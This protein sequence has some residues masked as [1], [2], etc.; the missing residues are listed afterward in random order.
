[1]TILFFLSVLTLPVQADEVPLVLVEAAYT[2]GSL[3]TALTSPD[4]RVR[5]EAA[6]AM[7]WRD[8]PDLA[9]ELW[10]ME[11]R[12][13][14]AG[15][16]RFPGGL[17]DKASASP[18]LLDR[19]IHGGEGV[20]VRHA[21]VDGI[22]RSRADFDQ[23][24]VELMPLEEDPWVRAAY[25]HSLRRQP[26]TTALALYRV[27]LEDSVGSVR[28]EAARSIGWHVDGAELSAELVSALG[29]S[30][31]EVRAQAARALGVLGVGEAV[32]PVADLLGDD[33]AE[34]RLQAL[35][36]VERLDADS[37]WKLARPMTTD[38][39]PRVARLAVRV[40]GE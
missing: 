12:P 30:E 11:P 22:A 5:H 2:D 13:T 27:G 34:V 29:D 17:V 15:F 26:A 6:V 21:L 14:R 32:D 40:S 9:A 31:S 37:A 33:D 35:H 1:M 19:L 23:A 20:G 36:A 7:T 25:L 38:N 28:A 4:W 8:Q 10:S 24:F 3:E 16:L 39:D 18:I